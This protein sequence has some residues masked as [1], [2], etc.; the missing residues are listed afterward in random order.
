MNMATPADGPSFG[1][2]PAGTWTWMSSRS[3]IAGSAPSCAA[4][5]LTRLSAAWALSFITSPSWPVRIRRPL[6]GIRVL[7]MNRMS[8]PTG[9]QARPVATPGPAARLATSASKRAGPRIGG[10]VRG[11]DARSAAA[12]PSA[13]AHRDAA[14]HRADLALEAAHAGFAGVVVHDRVQ[15]RVGQA[16]LRLGQ[17]VLLRAAAA[18][19]SGGRSRPSPPRCSRRAGPPPCGRAAGRGWCRAGW[20]WR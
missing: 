20:R 7:S 5:A 11:V 12:A 14:E 2:A 10:Q 19:G 1:M 17:P 3:N 16:G 8:P 13:T 9:V 15:R 4:R 18:R 6:P